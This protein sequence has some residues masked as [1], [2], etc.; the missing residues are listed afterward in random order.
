MEMRSD[1]APES[2]FRR[3]II[4]QG[5]SSFPILTCGSS[6]KA[7][8][9]QKQYD[10]VLIT[11]DPAVAQ[12]AKARLPSWVRSYVASPAGI[13]SAGEISA[14][15]LW[16][17]LDSTTR[18]PT[19]VSGIER[20][21]YFY[22]RQASTA[23]LL[24]P[25]LF[26][27]KPLS[28]AIFAMLW[29]GTQFDSQLDLPESG[30]YADAAGASLSMPAWLNELH[31]I[32]LSEFCHR[33]VS[34]VGSRLGF[35]HAA[36]YIHHP[37]TQSLG[38]AESTSEA[39]LDHAIRSGPDS[40]HLFGEVAFQRSLIVTDRLASVCESL[41]VE[42][43]NGLAA[44]AEESALIGA[45]EFGGQ[46]CG[47]LALYGGLG[48][49]QN[50]AEVRSCLLPFLSRGLHFARLHEQV[51]NEARI[52]GLTG[53]YNYRWAMESLDREISRAAR[54]GTPL[55]VALVDLDGLKPINDRLGHTAGD[56]ALRHVAAR[57]R[58]ILRQTDAAARIGGDEF[59]VLLPGTDLE[60]ARHVA[61]KL[62]AAVQDEPAVHNGQFLPLNVSAGAGT[63]QPGSDAVRL[64]AAADQA[65]YEVKRSTCLHSALQRPTPSDHVTYPH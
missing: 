22:S 58:S 31:E 44:H 50:E 26:L 57:I 3:H 56:C 42:I 10:L 6:L 49:V 47:V 63:W 51:H 62:I 2:G 20:R 1:F 14:H 9:H 35:H 61:S 28:D 24:P 5:V 55:S 25:G 65:M 64:I 32:E 40:R 18:I 17:D 38:L 45:L 59:L 37:G 60:G 23:T 7:V 53:L 43:P 30:P 12:K 54:Y 13:M 11:C 33:V 52:D 4:C 19:S 46:L 48:C 15:Q 29:P 34:L 27:R 41:G 16:L 36:L 39:P 21:I 8:M